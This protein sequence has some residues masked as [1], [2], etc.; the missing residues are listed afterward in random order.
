MERTTTIIPQAD[1]E[2]Q[3][4]YCEQIAALTAQW[5]EQPQIGR[6]HV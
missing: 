4:G 5:G 6:A 2:R 3:L 1:V